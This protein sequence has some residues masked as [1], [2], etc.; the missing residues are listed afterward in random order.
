MRRRLRFGLRWPGVG[1]FRRFILVM[2]GM[3]RVGVSAALD[4]SEATKEYQQGRK[5]FDAAQY[6]EAER[7]FAA[8]LAA[9]PTSLY[10]QWLGRAYGLEAKNAS[11]FAKPGLANR[12]REAL[13]RAVALDPDNVGARSDLAAFYHAAPGFMGGGLAKAQAQVAE[14]RQRDPYLGEVRAGDLLWDDDHPVEA[15]RAYRAAISLDGHRPQ[16]RERLGSLYLESGR[17]AQAFAQW[18]EVLHA[19]LTQRHALYG[20][21]KTAALSGQRI[22][23]GETAL[24]AFLATAEPDPDGPTAAHAHFYLGRLL[25]RRGNAGARGEYETA[26]RLDPGMENARKAL[27]AMPR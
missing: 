17:F 6:A 2:C 25:A 13:E 19:D 1:V 3:A 24:R 15:E 7:L 9:S 26:L 23:E 18:D 5:S 4:Q 16:A 12:T 27:A 21:G 11:M 20:L 14:I 8:A 10:A 22:D